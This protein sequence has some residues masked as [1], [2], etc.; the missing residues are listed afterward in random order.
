[1]PFPGLIQGL[2]EQAKQNPWGASPDSFVFWTE[3]K[4]GVPMR[5]H[6]LVEGLRKALL[7]IG[8]SEKEAAKYTFHGWRHFFTSYMIRKLDKKLLKGETG[9]K[10]DIMLAHYGDHET[11][12]DRE[13]IQ[14]TKKEIFAG[15]LPET[16]NTVINSNV[17]KPQNSQQVLLLEYKGDPKTTAA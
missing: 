10:T 14:L 4:N 1:M 6:I 17:I 7:D 11:A 13:T 12:W 16:E 8:F 5:D 15:L 2:V 9:H 3:N